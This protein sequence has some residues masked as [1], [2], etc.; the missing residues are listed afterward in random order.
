MIDLCAEDATTLYARSN[1]RFIHLRV[2][3]AGEWLR[4]NCR[5]RPSS[6]GTVRILNPF[7]PHLFLLSDTSSGR[8]DLPFITKRPLRLPNPCWGMGFAYA[9][10]SCS[11]TASFVFA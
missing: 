1:T 11:G 6:Y 4:C 5:V 9:E 8:L 7:G 2:G 3:N 10:F